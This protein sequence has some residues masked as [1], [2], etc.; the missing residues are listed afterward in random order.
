MI[1]AS[2][3]LCPQEIQQQILQYAFDAAYREPPSAFQPAGPLGYRDIQYLRGI[4][5]NARNIIEHAA[6]R[7]PGVQMRRTRNRLL[8]AHTRGEFEQELAQVAQQFTH[9]SIP[10][11]RLDADEVGLAMRYLE[12]L[13]GFSDIDRYDSDASVDDSDDEAGGEPALHLE[14][15]RKNPPMLIDRLYHLLR[16]EGRPPLRITLTELPPGP[17]D[18]RT[19]RLGGHII[20]ERLE[21]GGHAGL[22]NTDGSPLNL[23]QLE[24]IRQRGHCVSHPDAEVIEPDGEQV[25]FAMM[26]MQLWNENQQRTLASIGHEA[27]ARMLADASDRS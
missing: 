19:T 8:H 14:V 22:V 21:P 16:V 1:K 3:S 23:L 27:T 20:D 26:V 17:S 11:A 12:S 24:L 7:L 9:I 6:S 15:A 10:L 2:Y 13:P 18:F 25:E 5:R 4:D